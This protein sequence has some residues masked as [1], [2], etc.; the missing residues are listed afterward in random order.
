MIYGHNRTIHRTTYLD[1]ETKDGDVV[2]VW[3]RCMALPFKQV[4]VGGDRAKE[5]QSI[6]DLPELYA[7]EVDGGNKLY[8]HDE[9][10]GWLVELVVGNKI[11]WLQYTNGFNWTTEACQALRFARQED[12]EKVATPFEAKAVQHGWS[13]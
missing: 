1:V 12:A 3:F 13:D 8:E 6:R 4:E 5:M 11:L 10:M 7:V 9:E 2:S